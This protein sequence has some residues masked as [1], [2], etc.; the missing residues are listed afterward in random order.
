MIQGKELKKE[1]N[2]SYLGFTLD[3][4][5]TLNEHMEN[6][7]KK[8]N[9]RLNLLKRLA[10]TSW[11]ADKN[12]LRQLYLGYIRSSMEYS[13]ALQTISSK[14]A[15]ESVDKVQNHALRFISGGLRSTPTEA[16]EIHTNVEPLHLRREAAVVEMTERY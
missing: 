1:E 12:T 9:K 14:T 3:P 13:L 11:G 16:C 2:P 15:Q 6:V 5:M 4:R 10:S 8:A 7:R